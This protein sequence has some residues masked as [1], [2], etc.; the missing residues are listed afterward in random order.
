MEKINIWPE[1]P[2][3]L[4][5]LGFWHFTHRCGFQKKEE[6]KRSPEPSTPG[7]NGWRKRRR[8]CGPMPALGRT[9]DCRR[10]H[11]GWQKAGTGRFKQDSWWVQKETVYRIL[12]KG[13]RRN[14]QLLCWKK[15]PNPCFLLQSGQLL[16][17]FTVLKTTHIKLIGQFQLQQFFLKEPALKNLTTC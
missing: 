9:S 10:G 6:G 13:C 5:A 11:V 2:R 7:L 4:C 16:P 15:P 12:V 1:S 17:L 14:F 3:C 8:L